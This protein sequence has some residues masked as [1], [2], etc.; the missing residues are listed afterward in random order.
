M[1]PAQPTV[2]I[3]LPLSSTP[4]ISR[5]PLTPGLGFDKPLSPSSFI[6]KVRKRSVA[7]VFFWTEQEWPVW[8]LEFGPEETPEVSGN[9]SPSLSGFVFVFVF[10]AI[11]AA[12]GSFQ[13]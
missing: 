12:Y 9:I 10:R 7:T 8:L 2:F 4:A 1:I 3:P 6:N 5:T 13:G 11:P